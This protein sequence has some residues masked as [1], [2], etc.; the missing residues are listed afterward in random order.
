M[1]D[2]ADCTARTPIGQIV[3][4]MIC[5]AKQRT[6]SVHAVVRGVEITVYPDSDIS[7][8]VRSWQKDIAKKPMPELAIA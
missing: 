1:I 2:Y 8:I 5:L 3:C 4:E 6:D 7:D